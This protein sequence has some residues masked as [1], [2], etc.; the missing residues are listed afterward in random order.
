MVKLSPKYLEKTPHLTHKQLEMYE[1]TI[2]T[3]ATDVLVQKHQ[4]I[5]IH[6]ADLVFTGLPKFYEKNITFAV[7]NMINQN[8]ILKKKMTQ[9]FKG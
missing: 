7:S 5:S 8:Y 2:S 1:R 9:L 4:G 6:S 3:V